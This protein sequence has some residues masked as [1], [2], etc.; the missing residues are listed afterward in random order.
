[1]IGG[2]WNARNGDWGDSVNNPKGN[3]ISSWLNNNNLNSEL[4]IVA[5]PS[6]TFPRS[7]AFMDFFMISS[8]T[9]NGCNGRHI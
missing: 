4:T 1:M 8:K 9:I 6:P 5:P 3:K 2:D 7:G